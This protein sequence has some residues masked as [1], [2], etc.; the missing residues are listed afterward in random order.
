MRSF[1]LNRAR[2]SWRYAHFGCFSIYLFG[3]AAGSNDD[4]QLP[5]KNWHLLEGALLLFFFLSFSKTRCFR[6]LQGI[7]KPEI[8]QEIHN[9]AQQLEIDQSAKA[10][11]K[12]FD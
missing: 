12:S 6:T 8:S 2:A 11:I 9:E 10:Q 5:K 7:Q 3:M 4:L 1:H